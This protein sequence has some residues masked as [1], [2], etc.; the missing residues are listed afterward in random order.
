MRSARRRALHRP[1]ARSPSTATPTSSWDSF[2]RRYNADLAN[3]FGNLVNRT[4]TMANRY[5]EGVRPPPAAGP[6]GDAVDRQPMPAYPPALEGFLLHD[7]LAA[8]WEF[9][10]AANRFVDA[11][12]PWVLAKAG[13]DR[14]R[15]GRR[16]TPKRPRRSPRGVPA[17]RPRGRAV[18]ARRL[19]RGSS[20]SSATPTR[21]AP[22]ATAVRPLAR[23]AR[24][25]RP[26]R[27][28]GTRRRSRAALPA[29]RD[30]GRR[31][32]EARRLRS[33]ASPGRACASRRQPLPPPGRPIRAATS[34]S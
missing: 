7:A 18:H 6:L 2:V 16:A 24:L 20:P 32:T 10:G 9:V 25:G 4:V 12:Q 17:R 31:S 15:V 23:R 19:R 29:A 3:D 14:R 5:L 27:D 8:L 22:T 30:G 33:P 13:Q 28:R 1:C 34:T 26:R 21:T 11:E